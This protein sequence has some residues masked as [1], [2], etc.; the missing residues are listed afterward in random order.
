M[1]LDQ[2]ARFWA[3]PRLKGDNDHARAQSA[4]RHQGDDPH[5]QAGS[6]MT[7]N[8]R[9]WKSETG[10]EN[11]RY[12][13]TPNLSRQVYRLSLPAPQTPDGP[14]SSESALTSRRLWQTPSQG[15]IRS[16]T[17]D[18]TIMD[19]MGQRGKFGNLLE[20]VSAE[21]QGMGPRRL[22]PRFV[23]WL[24]GFPVSWTEL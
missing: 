8:A 21:T 22:N 5:T 19:A 7:P 13:K 10:S 2:Q 20:Q 11:N 23:E 24:M 14:P 17:R 3:T 12:N 4:T 6:W 18:V 1:G 16:D 9:D 15:V